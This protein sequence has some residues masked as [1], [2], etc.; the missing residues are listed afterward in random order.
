MEHA[1]TAPR[2]RTR[3]GNYHLGQHIMG[4]LM[5]V[6]DH[7]RAD[8]G[9]DFDGTPAGR[10]DPVTEVYLGKAALAQCCR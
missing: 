4:V 6:V 8:H 1:A 2:I 3:M 10:S 7:R 5:R 9:E